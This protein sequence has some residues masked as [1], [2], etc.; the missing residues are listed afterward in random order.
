MLSIHSNFGN[1]SPVTHFALW[2]D[3][4]SKLYSLN[5][6]LG[7]I[8]NERG[9]LSFIPKVEIMSNR[10][11]AFKPSSILSAKQKSSYKIVAWDQVTKQ[12]HV[13]SHDLM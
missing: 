12:I 8:K 9:E 7:G 11:L 4:Q 6:D 1:L 10:S 2:S 13:Y 3:S 5:I